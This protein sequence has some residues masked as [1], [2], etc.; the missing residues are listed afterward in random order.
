MGNQGFDHI[1][2]E[3]NPVTDFEGRDE[4]FVPECVNTRSQETQDKGI[5]EDE[6]CHRMSIRLW[7]D[8]EFGIDPEHFWKYGP[9]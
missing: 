6:G 9:H 4:E 8:G 7:S 5:E 1:N 3:G 2:N